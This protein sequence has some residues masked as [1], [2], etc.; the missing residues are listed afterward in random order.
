[1]SQQSYSVYQ[2]SPSLFKKMIQ[3]RYPGRTV[4]DLLLIPLEGRFVCYS[5]LEN[6]KIVHDC[7][8]ITA[9]ITN[10]PWSWWLENEQ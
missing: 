1:M 8:I 5:T 2:S 6:H 4:N 9:E 7:N 10:Y 3:D